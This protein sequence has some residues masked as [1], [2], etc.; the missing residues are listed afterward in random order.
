MLSPEEFADK[1][2][3]TLA[4]LVPFPKAAIERVALSKEDR[5]FLTAAGLPESAA[6]FLSFESPQS[7]EL[8]SVARTWGLAAD[9]ERYLLIGTDGSGNPIALD[10]AK[11]GE[12]VVL[13]HENSFSR[14]LMNTSVR[15]LAESLLAFRRLVEETQAEFGPDA[16]LDGKTAATGRDQLRQALTTID[17][18]AMQPGC[19]WPEQ[20]DMLA[21][22]AA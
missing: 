10:E 8:P 19:F 22:N 2:G 6:P 1:W 7:D 11:G 3:T 5:A 20:L 16:F 9:F 21:A 12:V 15:Q 4:A 13:D 14:T 18:P 17:P